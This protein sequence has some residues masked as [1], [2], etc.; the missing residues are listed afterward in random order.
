MS[1]VR[2]L[3]LTDV[4]D[5]TRLSE[6]MGDE[7][8]A[9][10]WAAHDRAARD[11]MQQMH[12]R[13][14]DK[15]DG[16]LVMFDAAADAVR[17]ARAY[18]AA[19]RELPAPLKARAGLHFGP[20]ILREN[21]A[22]DIALGAKPLEVDG[23]TKPTAA[24]VMSLARGGQ[25]LLTREARDA[26]GTTV[27]RVESHGHW[28]IKGVTDPIELFE[29]GDPDSRLLPPT[30]TDKAFR[31]VRAGEWWMPVKDIPNNLPHQSTSFVGREQELGEVKAFLAKSRMVT[32]LGMGGLG[33]TRLSL[34][35]A[36]ELIHTFP[37]GAWFL[38]LAPLR[39]AEL[40]FSE[41]AQALGVLEEPGKPLLQVICARL[42][43][44]R[45]LLI[46]D[47][48]EHLIKASADLA[49]AVLKAAPNVRILAS[50]REALRVPGEQAYPVRPLPVPGRGAG[51]ETLMTSTAV[52]L[53]VERAQQHKPSFTLNAK[54]APAVA[55]LVARLEGIPLALELAAARVRALTVVEIN[56]RLK[57]R[58][59]LLTGG[60]RVLQERQQTLRALVDWSYDLLN[61][62]EQCVL[63]RLSVFAGGFDLAA[64]EEVC[65]A[66]PLSADD[67]LD[68]LS[69]LVE[70]SLVMLEE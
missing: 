70:K 19:L 69:S 16:M 12:G 15:T 13:E 6:V 32:L 23:V 3:L 45:A 60:A 36:A 2:A 4:V 26:L 7:E 21:S 29:A 1:E 61:E 63:A 9:S 53:F 56:N 25:T 48:C 46:L 18:H 40:V 49:S 35:V 33:K 17:Y 66:E 11:L 58:Y 50:S 41:A 55:E 64:T 37:D 27:L 31:V 62:P 20:V 54:E 38:D 30:D 47:N 68:V 65:G 44:R 67:V 52:R 43:Q 59:K 14:I 22:E 10:L 57:D 24:R 5:S 8:M 34:E 51:V 39:D 28:Q 42:K